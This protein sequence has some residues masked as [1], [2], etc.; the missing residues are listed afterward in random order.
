LSVSGPS[1]AAHS[2]APIPAAAPCPKVAVVVVHGV[3]NQQ[4]SGPAH[5]IAGLL[6][7][8]EPRDVPIPEVRQESVRTPRP[9]ELFRETSLRVPRHP[10][11]VQSRSARPPS[12]QPWLVRAFN[13]RS[14][15]VREGRRGQAPRPGGGRQVE[16]GEAGY[17]FMRAQLSDYQGDGFDAVFEITRLDGECRDGAGAPAAEVHI[18]ELFWA[19][20]GRL[21]DGAVAFFSQFYQLLFHVPGLGQKTA[22]LAAVENAGVPGW[23]VFTALRAWAGRFLSI[24]VPILNLIMLLAALASLSGVVPQQLQLPVGLLVLGIVGA[25]AGGLLINGPAGLRAG[26]SWQALPAAAAGL[27][28]GAGWWTLGTPHPGWAFHTGPRHLLALELWLAGSFLLIYVLRGF[29]KLRPG[30][31]QAGSVL[32]VLVSAA[33]FWQWGSAGENELSMATAGMRTVELSLASLNTAWA[34]FFLLWAASLIAGGY[35]VLATPI[36]RQDTQRRVRAR[37]ALWTAHAALGFPTCLVLILTVALWSALFKAAQQLL[38]RGPMTPLQIPWLPPEQVATQEI[39]TYAETLLR[40]DANWLLGAALVGL[41]LFLIATAWGAFPSVLT[42]LD[43]PPDDPVRSRRLGV[44][45]TRGLGLIGGTAMAMVGLLL[46]G[47]AVEMVIGVATQAGRPRLIPASPFGAYGL[48]VL[49]A[50]GGLVL[51]L[52]AAKNLLAGARTV[53]GI[54]LEVDHYLAE[55]PRDRTSRA[56]IAERYVSLLR[57]LCKDKAQGG[58]GY[59][60]VV[61]IAHSQ[62]AVIT[63]DLLRFLKREP[64]HDLRRLGGELPLYFFTMG[65]P[66]RQLY[67]RCFPTLYDWVAQGSPAAP[68]EGGAIADTAAP[69]PGGLGLVRWVNAYRSGDYIGRNLWLADDDPERWLRREH[70]GP[71]GS[72]PDQPPALHRDGAGRRQ[73]MCL[74]TGAHNHYWDRNG[75]DVAAMLHELILLAAGR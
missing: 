28:V 29:S 60:G 67:E 66:Y 26:W 50:T 53:L 35:A 3:G 25:V 68:R 9:Y 22:D 74:G 23:R 57:H 56:R 16:P 54:L 70:Q 15:F 55:Y 33:Y 32:L 43:L 64:D 11:R 46:A 52:I 62:G 6:L 47:F 45:M 10:A 73:E 12:R 38:P 18:H 42:E 63:T 39:Q 20:L 44:W 17:E 4:P 58:V 31:L 34:L 59:T 1:G 41:F 27:A 24:P 49:V 2:P 37:R 71:A 14:D 30:A 13:E 36:D 21:G 40:M 5:A 8:L 65:A 72:A 51:S 7:G 69:D 19:D 48:E 61:I 75:R